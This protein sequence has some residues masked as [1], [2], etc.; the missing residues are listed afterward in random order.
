MWHVYFRAGRFF[1]P[2]VA[3]T[4]AGY[5][6]DIE[7]V[8]VSAVDDAGALTALLQQVI[9]AGNPP[10]PAPLRGQFP[11]PVIL[12]PAGVKSWAAFERTSVC[13]T[14]TSV[15]REHLVAATGRAPDGRWRDDPTHTA[16]VAADA[17]VAGIASAILRQVTAR[18]DL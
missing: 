18:D 15:G 1:V 9:D 2:V 5:Y 13:W 10:V 7:P 16:T 8:G 3:R 6:L 17:G 14:I 11:R 4:D 12:G